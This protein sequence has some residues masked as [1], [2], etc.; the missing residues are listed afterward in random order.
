MGLKERNRPDKLE[1][2][3]STR[4]SQEENVPISEL[5]LEEAGRLG[6]VRASCWMWCR[7]FRQAS[8]EKSEMSGFW[9]HLNTLLVR[10][11]PPILTPPSRGSVCVPFW[12][13]ADLAL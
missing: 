9:G 13:Q 10:I 7:H 8:L 6:R 11:P 5:E 12:L 3:A 4:K 1:F 2:L